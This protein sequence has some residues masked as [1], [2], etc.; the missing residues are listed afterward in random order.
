MEDV[1][2]CGVKKISIGFHGTFFNY[3]EFHAYKCDLMIYFPGFGC[4]ASALTAPAVC[5][6]MTQLF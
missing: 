3:N 4:G 2:Y 5:N 6:L 1:A